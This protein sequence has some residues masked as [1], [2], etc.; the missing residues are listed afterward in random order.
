MAGYQLFKHKGYERSVR[1][2][3]STIR[4]KALW[5]QVLL[6]I[7]GR[8]PSVKSTIGFDIRWRRTPVQGNHFYMWWIPYSESKI[9]GTKGQD[10]AILI[11]SI[12]HHDQNSAPILVGTLDD[13]DKL[14]VAE[15]DPRFDEQW[16]IVELLAGGPEH[17]S[18][19]I[20]EHTENYAFNRPVI[21]S[22]VKG[23]PG[24]GKTVSLY[25]LVRDLTQQIRVGNSNREDSI[26]NGDILYITY[27]SRLK[28]A[29]NDFLQA[30]DEKIAK[31]VRV[32]TLSELQSE[33]TGMS[34]YIEPFSA[35][36]DFYQ[37]LNAKNSSA[38][39]PWK[40]Y[41]QTLYTEVRA[42]LV[43]KN[44]PEHYP[45]SI[46]ANRIPGQVLANYAKSRKIEE[47]AA[48][49]AFK[50][51][52]HA[53]S[54]RFFVEQTSARN[55]LSLISVGA[56]HPSWLKNLNAIIVDEVQDFTL[57]QLAFLGELARAALKNGTAQNDG[58]QTA[59][60]KYF[61]AP[62]FFTI[63]GDESQIVQP[64]GFDW[65]ITKDLLS[66][67]L[68]RYPVEYEFQH[69]RRAPRLLAQIIENSWRFYRHLPKTHRPSARSDSF[70]D[71][72]IATEY[73]YE[74][75]GQVLLCFSPNWQ[76]PTPT[77]ATYTITRNAAS[78]IDAD[79]S[80]SRVQGQGSLLTNFYPGSGPDWQALIDELTDKPGR[81]LIDM[82]ETLRN[83]LPQQ[84][85]TVADDILFLSREIKGLERA[86]VII[87]GL[88]AAYERAIQLSENKDEG[89]IPRY[90]ARRIFDELRVAL[91]RSTARLVLLEPM[92]APVL[93]EL[94]INAATNVHDQANS[95]G[96]GLLAIGW[97]DLMDTLRTE[98]MAELEVI[99]GYL[100]EVEDL[101]ERGRWQQAYRRN[102]RA[103]EQALHLGDSALQRE[104]QEQH[105]N[106]YMQEASTLF[107]KDDWPAAYDRNRQAHAFAVEHGDP[108]LLESV[109]EQ[110]RDI[111]AQ[112]LAQA[113]TLHTQAK[114]WANSHTYNIALQ[115]AKDALKL[116]RAVDEQTL[117]QSIE[118]TIARICRQ[119]AYQLT[120]V[121]KST[122]DG[123]G[124]AITDEVIIQAIEL[125]DRSASATTAYASHY[126]KA[127]QTASHRYSLIPPTSTQKNTAHRPRL[128]ATKVREL[129][130]A[131]R[132]YLTFVEAE[133]VAILSSSHDEKNVR[134]STATV[135][136]DEQAARATPQFITDFAAKFDAESVDEDE[137]AGDIDTTDN[138]TSDNGKTGAELSA[139]LPAELSEE[140]RVR[141]EFYLFPRRW[142]AE[143]FTNLNDHVALYYLWAVTADQWINGAAT[144]ELEYPEFDEQLWELENRVEMV[145]D[146][147]N[148]QATDQV[149]E[150]TTGQNIAENNHAENNQAADTKL[151]DSIARFEAFIL[152]YHG[153]AEEASIAWEQLG[154]VE[155]AAEQARNAGLF[156][157]AY[158]LLRRSKSQLPEALTL[159]AKSVRQ[160]E[161]LAQNPKTLRPEERRALRERLEE[162]QN[163]LGEG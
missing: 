71:A 49:I 66:K 1:N 61:A 104:T 48:E 26:P 70:V 7:R 157:H 158:D 119:W 99:E 38:L 5:S 101:A 68:N 82:T 151:N 8:T 111:S 30:Q 58:F 90:E 16:Q 4:Q 93:T 52:E 81:V 51:S 12:R 77:D 156:E 62:F 135:H 143:A 138:D 57:I 87:Y 141:R 130:E 54:T 163:A 47:D 18:P 116:I 85:R 27:T 144:V 128:S 124:T 31:R 15:L 160:L 9:S 59:N 115:N 132:R 105:I 106:L 162:I 28:R 113:R 65:G 43:G 78:D 133:K 79:S 39:G 21:F 29:A 35:L 60:T 137:R 33:I 140:M 97:D 17:L 152:G 75:A 34:S 95:V 37:F 80:N 23:L 45:F 46:E 142:I 63:A 3:P 86:T 2:L 19:Q 20:S 36:T 41:P 161:Q 56:K 64:T 145:V 94:G 134:D 96:G 50:I 25:Y 107:A 131:T 14:P 55:A 53:A 24:S 110:R 139:E 120:D 42:H 11:H 32:L 129:L 103:H 22:T 148:E 13:Y 117:R 109:N 150:Q 102:R 123:V 89:N 155:F 126:A 76:A 6:G 118:Q 146:Q 69:Q 88:N 114:G 74:S 149:T 125:L 10:R 127:L 73:Q 91:S 83:S 159:A 147:V 112:I 98:E 108:L 67:Q 154:E 44:F 136:A 153:K 121:N 122:A 40:R 72:S 100:D 84:I 92:D